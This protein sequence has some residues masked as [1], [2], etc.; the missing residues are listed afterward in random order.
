MK[1]KGAMFGL[2]ARIALVIFGSLSVISG[3]TLHSAIVKAQATS[4]L[5]QMNEIGKAWKAYSTD[6]GRDFEAYTTNNTDKNFYLFKDGYLIDD[7]SVKGWDGP[8]INYS[9]FT[10]D[11]YYTDGKR[12][13][14]NDDLR[15]NLLM[16][17]DDNWDLWSDASAQCTSGKKCYI[18]V[19][20][21]KD[22]GF[23]NKSYI[24]VLDKD[25]DNGDGNNAGNL[26][27]SDS[28]LLFKYN[29]ISNPND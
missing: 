15:V 24:N 26:R 8:Y 12:V 10:V 2:D 28:H 23:I 27:W 14:I 4:K 7:Y 13:M 16:A 1:N 22:N 6:T 29:P 9:N 3:A 20:F 21:Y 5:N 18:W 11:P 17:T 19:G 25:L